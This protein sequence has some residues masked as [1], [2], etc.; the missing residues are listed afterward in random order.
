[1]KPEDVTDIIVSHIHW[2]HFD[3]ADLFPRARVWLQKEEIEYHVDSAGAVKNG[4]I[5]ATDAGMLHSIRRD[6]RLQS[7]DGDDREIIP[8]LRV[9]TG[10][11]HTYQSQYVSVRIAEGTVVLASDNMYMY[12]NL[13]RR[14]P[15]AQSVDRASNLAAQARMLTIASKPEFIIPGHDP[16][17]FARFDSVAP[18]VVR[19]R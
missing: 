14:T 7:V 1:V 6:G 16:A 3:G 19:I 13:D 12:E 5:D 2:D 11:K 8:G 10:G 9:Y 4:A 17:V 18:G 15:I